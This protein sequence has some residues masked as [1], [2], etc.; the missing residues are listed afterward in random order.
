MLPA[1]P[2][3]D[4][5]VLAARQQAEDINKQRFPTARTYQRFLGL[6]SLVDE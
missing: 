4:S 5:K 2:I 1:S 3:M 6:T